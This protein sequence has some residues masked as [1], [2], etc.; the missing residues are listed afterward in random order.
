MK[1]EDYRCTGLNAT[2]LVCG[3]RI[4][5]YLILKLGVLYFN[6][7][8]CI[9]LATCRISMDVCASLQVG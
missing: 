6:I 5:R 8:G 1:R 4:I 3:Y 9:N 2:V 7:I